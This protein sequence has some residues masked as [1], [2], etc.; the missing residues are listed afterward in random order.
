MRGGGGGLRIKDKDFTELYHRET[1]KI[2]QTP[3]PSGRNKA[4][5]PVRVEVIGILF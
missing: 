1:S 3:T 4:T 2:L 5:S